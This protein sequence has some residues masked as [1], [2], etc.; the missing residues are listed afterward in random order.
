MF[1]ALAPLL[2]SSRQRDILHTLN[3]CYRTK[4]AESELMTGRTADFLR[5]ERAVSATIN[6]HQVLFRALW[7]DGDD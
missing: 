6:L 7:T 2:L 3:H 4:Q 1:V 5:D